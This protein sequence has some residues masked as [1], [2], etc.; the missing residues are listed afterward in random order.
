MTGFDPDV[1][2]TALAILSQHGDE[3]DAVCTM[4]SEA[5]LYRGEWRAC[6]RFW[7]IHKRV[8]QLQRSGASCPFNTAI[9]A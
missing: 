2:H 1:T 6:L 8:K 9:P 3:A 7:D 4:H 5:L